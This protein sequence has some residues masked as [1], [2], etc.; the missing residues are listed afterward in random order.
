MIA[1]ISRSERLAFSLL[2]LLVAIA[3]TTVL[4]VVLFTS[5]KAIGN[6]SDKVRT[7]GN[8]RQLS[9]GIFAYIAEHQDSLPGPLLSL[10][11]ATYTVPTYSPGDLG[12]YLAPYVEPG[13]PGNGQ[14]KGATYLIKA[15]ESPAMRKVSPLGA[16][17]V[18]FHM[19]IN[20]YT[21]GTEKIMPFG[22]RSSTITLPM[23][24]SAVVSTFQNYNT[25]L[26]KV[27]MFV[28]VDRH[29]IGWNTATFAPL[30]VMP[31]PL[32]GNSR[33]ALFFDGHVDEFYPGAATYPVTGTTAPSLSGDR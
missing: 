4:A 33:L 31:E 30:G 17:A 7:V 18:Q 2:E 6:R 5:M 1:P 22:F 3:V 21:Q 19:N 13:L 14:Q 20:I 16:E 26:S 9:A 15:M 28:M 29:A 32:F 8:W 24:W 10:Q 23:R 12:Y 11:R 27:P 25:P